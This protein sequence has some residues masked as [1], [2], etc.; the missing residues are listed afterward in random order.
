MADEWEDK[1]K[2]C[3]RLCETL[4]ATLWGCD[5]ESLTYIHHSTDEQE[6][7]VKYRNGYRKRIDVSCDSGFGMIKDILRGL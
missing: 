4:R 3:N 7:V 6:V 5:I 1:Q 2:I